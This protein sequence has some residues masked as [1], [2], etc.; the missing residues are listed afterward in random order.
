MTTLQRAQIR[1]ERQRMEVTSIQERQLLACR[2]F[3]GNNGP[4][5][6][7]VDAD[8]LFASRSERTRIYGPFDR[9][10]M[11]WYR[12]NPFVVLGFDSVKGKDFIEY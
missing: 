12:D 4:K 9:G 11:E 1:R 5:L 7:I 8:E 3:Y 2:E 10:A 6:R